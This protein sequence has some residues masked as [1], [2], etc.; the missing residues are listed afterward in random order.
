MVRSRGFASKGGGIS[1]GSPAC[2]VFRTGLWTKPSTDLAVEEDFC[3]GGGGGK[4]FL[5]TASLVI[6]LCRS[7][8]KKNA[9][10]QLKSM[11]H[12]LNSEEAR[13]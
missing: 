9:V 12:A 7:P 1:P 5:V 10:H 13:R 4:Y 3:G 11:P 2:S 6:F 8:I